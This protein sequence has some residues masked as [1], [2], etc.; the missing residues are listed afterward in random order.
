M[1]LTRRD[2]AIAPD[3]QSFSGPLASH[4][5]GY[6]AQLSRKG[7]AQDPV[8]IVRSQVHPPWPR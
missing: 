6:V 1:S 3:G 4:I 5:E 2:A 7:H 8:H